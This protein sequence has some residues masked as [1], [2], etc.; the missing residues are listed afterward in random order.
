MGAWVTALSAQ[1]SD[2]SGWLLMGLPGAYKKTRIGS[3]WSGVRMMKKAVDVVLL[4]D[5]AMTDSAIEANAELVR[6]FGRKIVLNKED[7]LPHISLA[8]GCI[9]EKDIAAVENVLEEIAGKSSLEDLKVV[10]IKTATN[11]VGE[12]VSAFEVERTKKLQSLHE[13]VMEKVSPYL[14]YNV[15]ADMI[16]GNEEIA[17]TTLLWIKNYREK[18]SFANFS[19]HI[20]IGYG[21]IKT[22]PFPVKFSPSNLALCHLGNHCTCRKILVSIKV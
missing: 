15:T 10:G 1:A 11:S 8:M 4:P 21:E 12:K 5:E 16:Y 17:E 20:T 3:Q 19:P 7:C 2:M 22:G 6:R 13:E 14:S 9:D 18:S